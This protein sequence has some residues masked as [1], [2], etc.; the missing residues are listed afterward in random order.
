MEQDGRA[1]EVK[2]V[3]VVDAALGL[4]TGKLAAQ[5]AH[6][7][8]IAFLRAPPAA[9]RTWLAAGMTKIVLTCGSA[10][11]LLDLASQ[12]DRAGLPTALVR[13]A[14]RTVLA[15]GTATCVGIGP[16]EASKIDLVTGS[17]GLLR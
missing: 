5:V 6:A 10:S 4:P 11:E 13:D 8:I 7:A 3:I 9:Q 16:A 15:A 12:A 14:G 17:L 2:Q 1:E